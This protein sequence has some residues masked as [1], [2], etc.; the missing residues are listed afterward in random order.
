MPGYLRQLLALNVLPP[1]VRIVYRQTH[2]EIG[3][4]CRQDNF[5]TYGS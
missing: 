4:S 2:H 1:G 3:R 5:R